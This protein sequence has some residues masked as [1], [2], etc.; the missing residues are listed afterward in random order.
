MNRKFNSPVEKAALDFAYILMVKSATY[1]VYINTNNTHME[2]DGSLLFRA[3]NI[4]TLESENLYHS[5]MHYECLGKLDFFNIGEVLTEKS[6]KK[7]IQLCQKRSCLPHSFTFVELMA[8]I[9]VFSSIE[10]NTA[11]DEA[12]FVKHN[13]EINF[14]ECFQTDECRFIAYNTSYDR[15][16]TSGYK[17]VEEGF[18]RF[19]FDL[20][21]LVGVAK[22]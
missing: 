22:D 21:L 15:E 10:E 20:T 6:Q 7:M 19:A 5:M 4:E 17:M 8:Q 9:D 2:P 1:P 3:L 14:S 18:Q 11:K 12:E 16:L 13:L